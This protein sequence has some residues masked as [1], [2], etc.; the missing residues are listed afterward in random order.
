RRS[1]IQRL[2][3]SIVGINEV[4]P[5]LA[6]G[7]LDVDGDLARIAGILDSASLDAASYAG[8]DEAR[9]SGLAADAVLAARDALARDDIFAARVSL[10]VALSQARAARVAAEGQ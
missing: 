7:S 3:E 4:E 10:G 8:E 6:S 5:L 2:D 9:L 1:R